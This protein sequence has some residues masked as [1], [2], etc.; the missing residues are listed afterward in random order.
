MN[1]NL[2]NTA[3][4][5]KYAENLELKGD[6]SK[7]PLPIISQKPEGQQAEECEYGGQAEHED[8]T[9]LPQP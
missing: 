4:N 9:A 8:G 6:T 2:F 5:I 3:K 7:Y 1:V